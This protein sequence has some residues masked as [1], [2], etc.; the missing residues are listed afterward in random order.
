[1]RWHYITGAIFGVF[2][3]T[4]VFSGV[5][6]MEPWDWASTEIPGGDIQ[7]A[8]SGGTIS[9]SAFPAIDATTWNQVLSGRTVKQ[10]EFRRIQG[11][12]YFVAQGVEPTPLLVATDSLEIRREPFSTESL[13]SRVK[14]GYPD[15]PILESTLLRDYDAY[16]YARDAEPRLPVLRV[17]FDDEGGNWLYIDA[18][19]SQLVAAYSRRARLERWIYHGFHS[20]DFSFWYYNRPLWDIG[21]IALSLG[22][23]ALSVIGVFIGFRRVKRSVKRTNQT[24]AEV[25]AANKL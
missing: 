20:L 13:L 8:L 22:G 23:A 19:M 10:V 14:E 12:H 6:S 9:L 18:G 25:P 11:E 24:R 3:L 1:V 15:A 4:W 17:K 5:L 2:T 7:Q 16:Y 21:V